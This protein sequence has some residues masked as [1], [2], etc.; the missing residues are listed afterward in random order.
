MPFFPPRQ[1]HPS[2]LHPAGILA[3]P[4]IPSL[5]SQDAQMALHRWITQQAPESIPNTLLTAHDLAE[6]DWP[7]I[8]DNRGRYYV[9]YPGDTDIMRYLGFKT[10]E[11]QS[12]FL[13][14]RGCQTLNALSAVSRGLGRGAFGDVQ[15]CQRDD[16]LWMACKSLDVVDY[17]YAQEK[18]DRIRNEY[19]IGI[20]LEPDTA[21][22][23]KEE[24]DRYESAWI[25][26]AAV[27]AVG[28]DSEYEEKTLKINLFIPL[29]EGVTLKSF[30]TQQ[31]EKQPAHPESPLT[32]ITVLKLIIAILEKLDRLHQKNILHRDLKPENIMV[33][34]DGS[35]E[36]FDYGL[37]LQ[38]PSHDKQALIEEFAGTI[39]YSAPEIFPSEHVKYSHYSEKS[40][41]FAIGRIALSLLHESVSTI[42]DDPFQ[43]SFT[44]QTEGKKRSLSDYRN[45][46]LQKKIQ[47]FFEQ[48]DVLFAHSEILAF[49]LT[50]LAPQL[51]TRPSVQEALTQARWLAPEYRARSADSGVPLTPNPSPISIQATDSGT[52]S[53]DNSSNSLQRPVPSIARPSLTPKK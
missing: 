9:I 19:A 52:H 8:F 31:Q 27:Q 49:F 48:D 46:K 21:I 22:S 12:A 1:V 53:L 23:E 4:E 44:D 41:V 26:E 35:I 38:V 42:R 36:I 2:D 29:L 3:T 47:H 40:E 45:E 33:L 18:V 16:G 15:V 17:D 6:L 43:S 50:L 25:Q 24:I 20:A 7:V 51:E 11:E 10:P 13:Q 32:E 30:F 5:L 34:P 37:S 28:I 14:K 39:E